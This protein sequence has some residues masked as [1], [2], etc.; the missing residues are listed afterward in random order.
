MS[1]FN[2]YPSKRGLVKPADYSTGRV[3]INRITGSWKADR[4]CWITYSL[5]NGA[6]LAIKGASV[7]TSDVTPLQS[8]FPGIYINKG[9]TVEITGNRGTVTAYNCR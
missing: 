7:V 9:D 3:V 5:Y 8:G 1:I 4:D 6:T 2:A